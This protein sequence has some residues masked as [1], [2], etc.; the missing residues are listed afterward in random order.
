M[1]DEAPAALSQSQQAP[2]LLLGSL[3]AASAVEPLQP[4]VLVCLSLQRQ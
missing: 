2:S 3:E 4:Q 1:V